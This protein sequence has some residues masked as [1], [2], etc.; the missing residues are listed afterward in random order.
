MLVIVIL[1]LVGGLIFV[2]YASGFIQDVRKDIEQMSMATQVET[3]M[4]A[5][6]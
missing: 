2:M 4:G 1:G 6:E 3:A 5:R